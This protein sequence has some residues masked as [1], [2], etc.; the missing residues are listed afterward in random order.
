MLDSAAIPGPDDERTVDLDDG[1][2]E[3]LPD[4]ASQDR[5]AGSSWSE[6]AGTSDSLSERYLEERPPHWR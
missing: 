6:P 2:L 1:E 4:L 5:E 3:I